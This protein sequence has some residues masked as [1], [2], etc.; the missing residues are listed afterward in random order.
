[1]AVIFIPSAFAVHDLAFQLDG[2]VSTHAYTTPNSSQVYDWGANTAGNTST[3]ANPN[4]N[5]IFTVTD[6][7]TAPSGTEAVTNNPSLVNHGSVTTNPFDAA[8]FVRDFGSGTSCGFNSLSTTFCTKDPTTYATGSKDTLGVGNGGWQCNKDN[9]VNSKIDIMNAYSASYFTGG[10]GTGDHIIYFGMEKNKN[11]GT[12][13]VG[14]WLLQGSASCTSPTT[15]AANFNGAHQNKDVLV[16]SEFS[17]GGGVS[18]ILAFQWAA[19]A[20]G[21]LSGDGGCIDSNDNPNP[22][23]GGCNGQPIAT[24]N[25]DCKTAGGNDSL[26]ATTN[27]NCTSATLACG[28]PWNSTVATPWLTADATGGV[29]RNQIVSPDFFEGGI[30]LTKV[31]S[32]SGE[33]APSCFSTVVPDTR[34]SDTITATLFDFVTEQLGECSSSTVTTPKDGSGN[35][36]PAGGLTLPADPANASVTVEDSAAVTVT[37]L[38]GSFSGSVDF[39][40]CGPTATSSTQLCDGTSGNVGVDLGSK[41]ISASGTVTSPTATLTEAGRYCFRAD[42][43]S[44]TT[45]VPASSDSSGTECLQVNPRQSALVTAAGAGPVDFGN[46]VTDTAT[47]SNTVHEQGTGGPSGSDGSINPTTL[48]G[49]AGGTITFTLYKSDCSTLATGTGT[50]PQTVSVSGDGSYG[51]VSFTPD[52]PGVYHWVASYDGDSPNTLGTTHNSACDD[53]AEDVT[54]RQIPTGIE[55]KQSW[56]PQDTAT[57]SSTIGNL[58][59]GGSVEFDLYDNATCSGTAKFTETDSVAG[60]NQT[61]TVTTNNTTFAITTAFSDPAASVAG[62]YSWKVV[63]TPAAA[64]TAHLGTQSSCNAENHSITYTNDPGP[65]TG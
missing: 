39:H 35:S 3:Q 19:A 29:G 14:V 43:S 57:I 33:T 50:N 6:T 1:M 8:S 15:G 42:F 28:K 22:K 53:T 25:S 60:G 31:F 56:Y 20:S 47:L 30:D 58:A 10:N 16:V 46:A 9:N 64:D 21:P 52:S 61:A 41:S 2:D 65:N 26:C 38:S 40:I 18:A 12:N 37:G 5:G 4:T 59:A 54:V 62:P 11:N 36:I 34:S 45:G 24:S 51:P 44:T 27:A 13:D 48:G 32:Q 49:D 23:T 63:Y 55:T 7:G 17:N